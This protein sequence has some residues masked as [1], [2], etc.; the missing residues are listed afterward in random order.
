MS[1]RHCWMGKTEYNEEKYGWGTPEYWEHWE[2]SQGKTCLLPDGH[3]GPHE[4]TDDSEI[5]VEFK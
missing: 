2:E 5:V 1:D 4:W 3:D